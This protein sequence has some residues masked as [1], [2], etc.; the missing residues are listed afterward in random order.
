MP[1]IPRSERKTQNRVIALFTDTARPDCLGY[2]Y[3]GEWHK[4][5]NNRCIEEKY[6]R[7]NLKA[8]GYSEAHIS[9]ALQKLLPAAVAPGVTLY[10]ANLRAYQ[11]L[12]SAISASRL[13]SPARW[14]SSFGTF[15]ALRPILRDWSRPSHCG[16]PFTSP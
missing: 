6:L 8:R 1:E 13:R 5:E 12:R 9:A 10:Q 2:R 4:R 3:L 15:A 7:A 16:F 14:S 11:L